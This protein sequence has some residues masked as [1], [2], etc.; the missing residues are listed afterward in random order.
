MHTIASEE[1]KEIECHRQQERE[2]LV[3]LYS[4]KGLSGPLLDNVVDVLMA[5]Q[6]RLLRIMLQ[7]EMGL[8]LEERVHPL[9]QGLSAAAGTCAS[10]VL[11]PFAYWL[12]VSYT[13]A[14]GV[15]I[16][17]GVGL[18]MARATGER[19]CSAF[20]WNGMIAAVS[21][22]IVHACLEIFAL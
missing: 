6:E 11:L 19:G 7:E 4:D 2:E 1:R 21:F 14:V 13:V 5:D 22:V 3:A 15:A 10:L 17:S 18:F 8:H 20:V 12:P 9:I 16:V